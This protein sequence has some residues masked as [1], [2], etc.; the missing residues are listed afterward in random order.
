MKKSKLLWM[1]LVLS[2]LWAH[3]QTLKKEIL[4]VT[5]VT[6]SLSDFSEDY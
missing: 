1:M 4:K 5:Y 6:T 2:L 3:S